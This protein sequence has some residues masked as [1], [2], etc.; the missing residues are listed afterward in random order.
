MPPP[1]TQTQ[2]TSVSEDQFLFRMTPRKP[3]SR[4][5]LAP[6]APASPGCSSPPNDRPIAIFGPAESSRCSGD[7]AAIR[8]C[9]GAHAQPECGLEDAALILPRWALLRS[10]AG[11]R[12]HP[13]RRPSRF[14]LPRP[15][16][17]AAYAAA[18]PQL[19]LTMA[20][21]LFFMMRSQAL[22]MR[23]FSRVRAAEKSLQVSPA[24][25]TACALHPCSFLLTS[26]THE[27]P[28]SACPCALAAQHLL[29]RA[30]CS[31]LWPVL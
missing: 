6:P 30:R 18:C 4:A 23:C 8:R 20:D 25:T 17:S 3:W 22:S 24:H 1:K 11:C 27:R 19:R 14:S 29:P 9:L 12:R 15:C 26:T 16:S 10:Q 7:D 28:G 13:R 31:P 2:R 5:H 21:S